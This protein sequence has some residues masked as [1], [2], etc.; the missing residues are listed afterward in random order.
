MEDREIAHRTHEKKKTRATVCLIFW[1]SWE[2]TGDKP[3]RYHSRVKLQNCS[4]CKASNR[5]LATAASYS[6]SC[7]PIS[8]GR[9]CHPSRDRWKTDNKDSLWQNWWQWID[10]CWHQ[11]PHRETVDPF[12]KYNWMSLVYMDMHLCTF[13]S[14]QNNLP[15]TLHLFIHVGGISLSTIANAFVHP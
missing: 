2:R 3:E 5:T 13:V 10:I 6:I 12:W 7:R 4:C 9:L 14:M 15:C 11:F 1:S 8:H